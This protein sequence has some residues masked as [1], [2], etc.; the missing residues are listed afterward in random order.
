MRIGKPLILAIDDV[1]ENLNAISEILRRNDF[2]VM[3]APSGEVALKLLE[4]RKPDLILLDIMMPEMDGYTVATIIQR[5]QDWQ[6]IPII[7][8]SALTDVDAK[9]KGFEVGG[10]DY[11]TK[12]F[13]EKEVVARINTHLE[14][15]WLRK[16]LEHTINQLREAN[17]AKDEFLRVISHDLRSPLS[18]LQNLGELLQRDDVAKD[19]NA[20]KELG[21]MIG[22]VSSQLLAMVN[23]LLDIAKIES[24]K[25]TLNLLETNMVDLAKRSAELLRI[26]AE[27]KNINF[28]TDFGT[29]DVPVVVDT[30]KI[31]QV[32]NNL[33]SNA[34][35]FTHPGGTVTLRVRDC[36]DLVQIQVSDTGIGIPQEM[37]PHLFEKFGPHQ[38]PGTAGEKGTGLGMPIIKGFVELHGG[39]V[40]VQSKEGE[41]T[42]VTI[43][44]PK[45]LG[46]DV[47]KSVRTCQQ[48]N[49]G[50]NSGSQ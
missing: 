45:R 35:K 27:A 42:T 12:P 16:S 32:I 46:V 14:L 20:I 36:G 25:F 33:L 44:L 29:T 49:D 28:K 31:G 10:V 21:K 41:G 48:N 43:T 50:S 6:D 13:M 38:R 15:S 19:P 3:V 22:E 4:R 40:D 26:N 24:G 7:F 1:E 30:A 9:V 23:G 47:E 37:L 2:D 18:S 8:L 39:T 5:R 11:I 34:I 17:Q